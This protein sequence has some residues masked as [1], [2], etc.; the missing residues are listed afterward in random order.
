MFW[1]R[2]KR[3][4]NPGSAHLIRFALEVSMDEIDGLIA[5]ADENHLASEAERLRRHRQT[6]VKVHAAFSETSENLQELADEIDTIGLDLTEIEQLLDVG[7]NDQAFHC[8]VASNGLREQ[9]RIDRG[10]VAI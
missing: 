2:K 5:L 8:H 6:V 10:E 3:R 7:E 9:A 1:K 4:M